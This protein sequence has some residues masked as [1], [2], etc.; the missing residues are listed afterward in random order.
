M[1]AKLVFLTLAIAL[2]GCT[3]HYSG[4]DG[5][6]A[7]SIE[8]PA[9]NSAAY[10]AAPIAPPP[11]PHPMLDSSLEYHQPI[12]VSPP[13]PLFVPYGSVSGAMP[14]IGPQGYAW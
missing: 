14:G 11:M 3:G 8:A 5:G 2:G 7:V 13:A 12:H 4:M 6:D 1:Y 10:R 9:Y